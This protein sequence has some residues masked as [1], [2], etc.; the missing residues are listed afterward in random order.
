M[1]F[2]LLPFLLTSGLAMA[3]PG[4][5]AFKEKVKVERKARTPEPRSN[6]CMQFVGNWQGVCHNSEGMDYTDTMKI[7][8][9]ACDAIYINDERM[10]LTGAQ[11]GSYGSDVNTGSF[12]ST[13]L[14]K[15]ANQQVLLGRYYDL[16]RVFGE[17]FWL[18]TEATF[19]M[20]KE[21][22]EIVT[23]STAKSDEY[24]MEATCRFSAA[25]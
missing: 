7:K 18:N 6:T 14:W 3:F 5:N 23:K 2:L 21:G 20:F 1:R 13:F 10:D 12:M 25:P 9:Y 19:E 8:Q 17:S 4:L 16:E 24:G 15:D 11:T 22:S